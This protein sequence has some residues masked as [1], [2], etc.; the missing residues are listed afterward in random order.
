MGNA[1]A[2]RIN[3]LHNNIL[4]ETSMNDKIQIDQNMQCQPKTDETTEGATA[5]Q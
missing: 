3:A 4:R 1:E 2:M 5:S